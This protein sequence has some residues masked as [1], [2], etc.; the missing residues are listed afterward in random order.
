MDHGTHK[1]VASTSSVGQ[2]CVYDAVSEYRTYV[3]VLKQRQPYATVA[4]ALMA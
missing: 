2:I 1:V 4:H 3:E